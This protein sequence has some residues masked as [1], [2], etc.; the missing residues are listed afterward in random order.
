[1]LTTNVVLK[2]EMAQQ[3]GTH[4]E[5]LDKNAFTNVEYAASCNKCIH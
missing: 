2:E 4:D 1:M 5:L 3:Q